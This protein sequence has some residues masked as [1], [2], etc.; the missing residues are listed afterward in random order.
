MHAKSWL[1]DVKEAD[2]QSENS[3]LMLRLEKNNSICKQSVR[4]STGSI[5]D[6]RMLGHF[7]DSIGLTSN[8]VMELNEMN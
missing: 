8:G 4:M 5:L 1:E 2:H 3:G 6:I 7:W